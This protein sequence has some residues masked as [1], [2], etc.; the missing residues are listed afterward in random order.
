MPVTGNRPLGIA[1]NNS[2]V[3]SLFNT[4]PTPATPAARPTI[5]ANLKMR[6]LGEWQDQ[7]M[8]ARGD[9]KMANYSVVDKAVHDGDAVEIPL[10]QGLS[11]IL[12]KTADLEQADSFFI[13]RTSGFAPSIFGPF[14]V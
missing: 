11:V 5:S 12:K 9:P 4:H 8:A 14:D 2:G 13:R 7:R 10:Q 6:I 3:D 1:G